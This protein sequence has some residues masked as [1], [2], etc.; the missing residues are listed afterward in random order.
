MRE[1]AKVIATLY[2]EASYVTGKPAATG[3]YYCSA[4][5]SL[6]DYERRHRRGNQISLGEDH[7]NSL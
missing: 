4:A 7:E 1:I 3:R 2:F 6:I 5:C